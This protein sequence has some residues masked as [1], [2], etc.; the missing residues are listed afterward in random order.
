MGGIKGCDTCLKTGNCPVA[1]LCWAFTETA[2]NT[3]A[4]IMLL[5]RM[6]N[7]ILKYTLI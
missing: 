7:T 1:V 5:N 6:D 4:M 3:I 2:A